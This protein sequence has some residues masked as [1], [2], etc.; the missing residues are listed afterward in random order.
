REAW[1]GDLLVVAHRGTVR[2]ALRALLQLPSG[3]ADPFAVELGSLSVLRQAGA[4]Q[5]DLL[6]ALP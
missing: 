3:N 2:Q 5:L 4:W 6:G 1:Q